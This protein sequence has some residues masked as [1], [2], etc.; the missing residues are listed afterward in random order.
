MV[1]DGG[2]RCIEYDSKTYEI[3]VNDCDEKNQ[4]MLWSFGSM[5][6]TALASL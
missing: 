6:K 3:I 1:A 2:R 5:N 4:K